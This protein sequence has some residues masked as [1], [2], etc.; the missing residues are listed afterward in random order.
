MSATSSQQLVD[1]RV[2]HARGLGERAQVIAAGAARMQHAAV[3][4]GAH[5]VH[6]VVEVVIV[7][8]EDRRA[9]VRRIDEPEQHPQRRRLARAVGP[10]E[11]DDPS[12]VDGE[13]QIVDRHHVAESLAEVRDLDRVRHLP[14]R[15]GVRHVL[16]RAVRGSRG[17]RHMMSASSPLSW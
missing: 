9:A 3:Q 6:G 13:R 10:E 8:A 17:V 7:G 16:E 1:A 2:R 12:L 5:L 15:P 11:P 4:D 14:D